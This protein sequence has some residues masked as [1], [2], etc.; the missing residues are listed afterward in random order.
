MR[1]MVLLASAVSVFGCAPTKPTAARREVGDLLAAGGGPAD[2]IPADQDEESRGRVQERV[3]ALLQE[4][5]TLDRALQIATAARAAL[6]V[7][8]VGRG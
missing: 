7:L 6:A 8:R 2:A 1:R 5:L 3:A 4:P